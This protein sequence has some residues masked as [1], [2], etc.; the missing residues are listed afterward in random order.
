M[1]LVQFIRDSLSLLFPELCAGCKQALVHQENQ[2]CTNCIYNLPKPNFHLDPAN[3]AA[4]PLMGR[5]PVSTVSSFLYYSYGSTVQ[6]II[7]HVKYKDGF[8]AAEVMGEL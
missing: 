4:K 8:A 2:L 7:H 6:E 5:V 1:Q 3:L